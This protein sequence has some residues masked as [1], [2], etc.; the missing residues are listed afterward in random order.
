MMILYLE[1]LTDGSADGGN[2]RPRSSPRVST[3]ILKISKCCR[4]E[5]NQVTEPIVYR[6]LTLLDPGDPSH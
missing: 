3:G 6:V 4:C 2:K 5:Q 1:K